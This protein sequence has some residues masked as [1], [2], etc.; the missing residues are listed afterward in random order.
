MKI[1]YIILNFF[2]K[3]IKNIRKTRS[4]FFNSTIYLK[5]LIKNA[6]NCL[7]KLNIITFFNRNL[8]IRFFFR[9]KSRNK[10]NFR[11]NKRF[12]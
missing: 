3:Y 7:I 6:T 11:E 10:S 12:F 4:T 9:K 8:I 1:H 2:F 5:R